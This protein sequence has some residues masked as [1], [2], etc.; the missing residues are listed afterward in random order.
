[1]IE[2]RNPARRTKLRRLGTLVMKGQD[3][4]ATNA[5]E[6]ACCNSGPL[7]RLSLATQSEGVLPSFSCKKEANAF[8][9]ACATSFVI[10]SPTMPRA[11]ETESISGAL[12]IVRR[13]PGSLEL[14]LR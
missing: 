10:V 3:P 1:M 14:L 6:T 9:Y 7:G 2:N 13:L 12:V 4:Q 11:P 5:S 8:A